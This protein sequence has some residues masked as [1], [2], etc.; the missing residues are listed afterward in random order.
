MSFNWKK[1]WPTRPS[2]GVIAFVLIIGLTSLLADISTEGA[3]SVA[4]QY[5]VL[6]GASATSIAVIAG[7]AEF[8]GYGLRALFGRVTDSS[9]RYW[10]LTFIGFGINVVAVPLLALAGSWWFAASLIVLE[11][12]GRAIR[13][14][15]RDAM[16]SHTT[17]KMGRGWAF[18]VQEALSSVGGML[19]PIVVILVLTGSGSYQ[20]AFGLLL[21]PVSLG[22][23]LLFGARRMNPSPR[24][25]EGK[26][27]KRDIE[28][29]L[30]R[31]FWLY[32][33]AGALIAA[34]YADFPLVAFHL[35]SLFPAEPS[36][37]PM[38][39][40]LVQAADAISALIFGWLYDRL[41]M[42]SL[43]LATIMAAAFPIV[44]FSGSNGYVPLAMV[45]YGIGFGAQESVM[46]A[47]VA[48]L[49]PH[50]RRATAFGYYN[51]MFGAFWLAG[52]VAMGALYG[53]S[54]AYMV[55]FSLAIQITA[56]PFLVYVSRTYEFRSRREKAD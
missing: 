26:C 3:R 8:A 20:A 52:S 53:I 27:A 35:D 37:I 13:G 54:T 36:A 51:A 30:S 14:P 34:G 45:L 10:A 39:Y 43:I 33:L 40:A 55:G 48:D 5:L 29:R 50:C 32:A 23:V 46:R 22:L 2:H 17:S 18:G 19:G 42:S 24:D 41:G 44:G 31:A 6:L 47:I 1:P 38:L 4:G 15:A 25:I 7:V 49:A 16:I 56:I 21:L 11:K 28:T 12:V 9:G